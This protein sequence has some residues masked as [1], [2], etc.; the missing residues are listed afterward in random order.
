LEECG[1]VLLRRA[2]GLLLATQAVEAQEQLA[3]RCRVNV[4][5]VASLEA[6]AYEERRRAYEAFI[7]HYGV[8]VCD[9]A[10]QVCDLLEY[11]RSFAKR[12][13]FRESWKAITKLDKLKLS[14]AKH[15][16][17]LPL[18]SDR[19]KEAFVRDI[20]DLVQLVWVPPS[21]RSR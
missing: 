15:A 8:A 18:P 6:A 16:A 20:G 11:Y 2:G 19:V 12:T 14:L 13:D 5:T 7:A 10:A 1:T 4:L 21:R 9:L 17:F 3:M